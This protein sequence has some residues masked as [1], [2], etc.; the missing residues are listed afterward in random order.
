MNSPPSF[1]FRL[2]V[3]LGLI[4]GLRRHDFRAARSFANMQFSE[5]SS[6]VK[7]GKFLAWALRQM[8]CEIPET[9]RSSSFEKPISRVPIWLADGNPWANYPWN[10]NPQGP[11]SWP[12]AHG[13]D[14]CG[15]GGICAS[16]SLEQKG[17][18]G[19]DDG[20][21]RHGRCCQ[22]LGRT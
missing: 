9:I 17:R 18:P 4:C 12:R 11:A 5:R 15:P 20:T 3:M 22:R 19:P 1:W 21:A 2:K 6:L 7:F 13:G 16:L 10:D 14:R 8:W